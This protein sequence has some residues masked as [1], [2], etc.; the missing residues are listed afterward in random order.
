LPSRQQTIR[1][2]INWSFNLLNEGEKTLFARLAVFV[3]GWT[4]EAAEA[5]SDLRFGTEAEQIVNRTSEIVHIID[6]LTSLFDKSM[7][8]QVEGSGGEPRFVMLETIRE[9]ALERLE[10]SGEVDLVRRRHAEYYLALAERWWQE[11]TGYAEVELFDQLEREHDN[12]RAA[13]NWSHTSEDGASIALRL[14][15]ALHHFF[16]VRGYVVE[17]WERL[18]AALLRPSAAP[19]ALRAQALGTVGASIPHYRDDLAQA[20]AFIEEGLALN[21][22]LGNTQGVAWQRNKL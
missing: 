17:G 1:D 13:L 8:R 5:V 19:D 11:A 12:L 20:K 10:Q 6:G 3:G 21:K 14:V 4:I 7:V 9:Y 15:A 16:V 22:R 2:T 18:K